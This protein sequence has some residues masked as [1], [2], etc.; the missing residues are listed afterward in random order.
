[1]GEVR[2][3]TTFARWYV[4]AHLEDIPLPVMSRF[5]NLENTLWLLSCFPGGAVHLEEEGVG[6]GA[7]GGRHLRKTP[8]ASQLTNKE[9]LR[10]Q[11]GEKKPS[12]RKKQ[13]DKKK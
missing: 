2:T 9:L 3:K 4:C 6:G 7:R 13:E 12:F 1:M 11:S 10:V 8:F 5:L